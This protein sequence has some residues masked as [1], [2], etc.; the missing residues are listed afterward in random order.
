MAYYFAQLWSKF[1]MNVYPIAFFTYNSPVRDEP[2]TYKMEFP[3]KTVAWVNFEKIE[4][5][6][7]KWQSF[8]DSD[9][10]VA[11]ALMSHMRIAPKDRPLV[12]VS[13]MR[14]IANM[15]R[16]AREKH[17]IGSFV[18]AYL[19]LTAEEMSDFRRLVAKIPDRKEKRAM[20]QLTTSWEREGIRKGL[21]EGT[22]RVTVRLL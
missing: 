21:A 2:N 9:N 5:S 20:L 22:R 15:K 7:L 10:P 8:L 19:A 14:M 16:T 1:K 18:E 12:K 3:N 4:M 17:V 11:C 6:K 13:C